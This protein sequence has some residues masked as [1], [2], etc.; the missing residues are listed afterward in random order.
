MGMDVIQTLKRKIRIKWRVLREKP[1]FVFGYV[2]DALFTWVLGLTVAVIGFVLFPAIASSGTITS[3]RLPPLS[4]ILN[5]DKVGQIVSNMIE[6]M[7]Q[8]SISGIVRLVTTEIPNEIRRL[9]VNLCDLVKRWRELLGRFVAL[10]LAPRKIWERLQA[11][12]ERYKV[13]IKAVATQALGIAISFVLLKIVL[14]IVPHISSELLT[15]WGVNVI[16]FILQWCI[17]F[18]SPSIA[19]NLRTALGKAWAAKKKRKLRAAGGKF[20]ADVREAME[21]N[22]K[23][24]EDGYE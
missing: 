11:F 4:E 23:G 18:V 5:V 16:L 3:F 6:K 20:I 17:S 14:Y 1:R 7:R 21:T 19:R 12:W 22:R 15:I 13:K 10:L 9:F 2:M 24:A 8:F